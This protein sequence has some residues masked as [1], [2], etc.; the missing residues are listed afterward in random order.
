MRCSLCS[1][2]DLETLH[3]TL[4]FGVAGRAVDAFLKP[5]P[6]KITYGIPVEKDRKPEFGA[7][8]VVEIL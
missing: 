5:A 2:E 8:E 6:H 1:W 4:S 7:G 3:P